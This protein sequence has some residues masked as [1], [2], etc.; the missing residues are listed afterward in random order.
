[1]RRDRLSVFN[2]PPV[3]KISRDTG[4]PECVAGRGGGES[5][6][7][8]PALDHPQHVRARHR[9]RRN[10]PP[11]IN[12]PKQ[13]RFLLVPDAGN[14]E[15]CVHVRLGVVV[16]GHF[17]TLA[18]FLVEPQRGLSVAFGDR[19]LIYPEASGPNEDAEPFL[20]G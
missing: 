16:R 14:F 2:G 7:E 10:P 13:R 8:R 15:V 12:T 17:V 5:S 11:V 19:C 9:I 1:M 20:F 18:A 4:S 3:L 6:I